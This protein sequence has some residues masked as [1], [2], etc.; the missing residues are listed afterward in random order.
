MLALVIRVQR[1][2]H[3]LG[4]LDVLR[5]GWLERAG[6]GEQE[7][8]RAGLANG[9][10]G[11]AVGD[12]VVVDGVEVDAFEAEVEEADVRVLFG[13]GI[14]LNELMI[15]DLDEGFV[16]HAVFLEVEC[17]LEAELFVEGDGGGEV[18][19]TDGDVGDAVEG[20]GWG[21]VG[22]GLGRGGGGEEHGEESDEKIAGVGDTRGRW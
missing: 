3:V 13:G 10:R 12:V 11:E 8:T 20:G 9:G 22:L 7:V 21:A 4:V 18:V 1:A 14:E 15:V 19:N 16:G 2:G 17:L 5:A 6:H